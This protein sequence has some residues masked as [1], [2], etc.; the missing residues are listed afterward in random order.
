MTKKKS[1]KNISVEEFD[2]KFDNGEDISEYLDWDKAVFRVNLDI[3]LWA[4]EELDAESSRR[5]IT[6][7]SLMK[8]WLIDQIDAMKKERLASADLAKAA[9]HRRK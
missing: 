4:V 3:P 5:G 1:T 8:T 6:R 9:G 2:R 7:Q